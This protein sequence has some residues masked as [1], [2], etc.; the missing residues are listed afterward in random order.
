MDLQK[1]CSFFSCTRRI[2]LLM[3]F[4]GSQNPH[5]DMYNCETRFHFTHG[6]P[7]LPVFSLGKLLVFTV[8]TI[9]IYIVRTCTF[10]LRIKLLT[11]PLFVTVLEAQEKSVGSRDMLVKVTFVA[12]MKVVARQGLMASKY[13]W[14]QQLPA[15]AGTGNRRANHSPEYKTVL[16]RTRNNTRYC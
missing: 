2:N 14:C 8:G 10:I 15:I 11:S 6:T 1:Y 5:E 12:V 16:C 4:H 13:C 9:Y 3:W 7:S